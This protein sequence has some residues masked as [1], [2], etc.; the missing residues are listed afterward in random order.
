[1]M[2]ARD[3]ESSEFSMHSKI[4]SVSDKENSDGTLDV[5]VPLSQEI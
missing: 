5:T 4:R 2:A 1:M 3:E